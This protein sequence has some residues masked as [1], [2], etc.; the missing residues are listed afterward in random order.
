M[1]FGEVHTTVDINGLSETIMSEAKIE[2]LKFKYFPAYA[3]FLLDNNL[4]EFAA[5]MLQ[6]SREVNL[7]LLKLFK[8][9]PE[10][11]LIKLGIQNTRDSLT[12]C[13]ANKGKELI[14]HSIKMWLNNEIPMI[15]RDLIVADDI[16]LVSFVRRK[17]FRDFLFLYTN[18]FIAYRNIMEEIDQFTTELETI[19]LNVLLNR[20][21][22]LYKQAQALAHIGNWVWDL[23]KNEL[24]WSEELYNIYELE[25][26]TE[27]NR[28]IIGS[29]NHPDDYI[30][31]MQQMQL[32]AETHKP[33]DF[34]YR[35]I[36]KD[37][38][39]KIL[40]AKGQL[41]VDVNNKPLQFFGTLQ[42][43]TV[44]KRFEKELMEKQNFIQKITHVTPSL[45]VTYNIQTGKYIFVNNALKKLLGYEPQEA[46]DK[47]IGFFMP[48]IHPDDLQSVT[49]K[50]AKAIEHANQSNAD[51]ETI[52][53]FQYRL[54]HKNGEYRWFHT[55]GTIFGHDNHGK[56]EYVLNISVD[57]THQYLLNKRLEEEKIA[58]QKY[59]EEL[60]QS[61]DRYHRMTA[62][63]QDYA[64]LLLDK[65]GTIQNWNLGA[66]K[67]KG[68]KAEEII[69]KNFRVFYTDEDRQNHR[70]DKLLKQAIETGKANDE[71]WRVRKDGTLFWGS[72][73]ITALHDENYDV[74]GFS[75]VTRDLTQRKISEDTMQEYAEELAKKNEELRRS[76]ERY[77]RMIAEVQDYAILLLDKEGTI[78]NWNLGAEKIKG[79]KAEEI[80]GKNFRIFYTEEDRQN[81]RPDKLL[82]QAI[83]TG[84]ANDEGWRVRKDGTRFWGSIVITALH[85]ENNAVIGL[86]KVTRDL[87]ER[88]I[89]EEKLKKNAEELEY[90]NNELIKTNKELESFNYIASHDLQEPLHKIQIFSDAILSNDFENLSEKGKK[91]FNRMFNAANRMQQLIEDF[92][93]FSRATSSNAKFEYADLNVLLREVL[94]TIHFAIEDSKAVIKSGA[95]PSAYVIPFQF[96]QVL[97]NLISNS[98]KYR[99]QGSSPHITISA[100]KILTKNKS[101]N[102]K[103]NSEYLMLTITDEGIGFDQQ[104]A[105]KI[106]ELFQRLHTKEEYPGTGIGLA[107]V[108]KIIQNHHG[109]IRAKSSPGKG[110]TFQIY[111]PLIRQVT[112]RV[113]AAS[114]PG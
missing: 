4:E 79:Y 81:H 82:K 30:Y 91:Y 51:N 94:S 84:K 114:E 80:I 57:V 50:N 2:K 13:A 47:G 65:E 53:E 11:Q 10:E 1:T 102:L 35:I 24:I 31:V 32:L 26:G 18:D 7:P 8:S 64:I 46:M 83:E 39:E 14:E 67:I 101:R 15:S 100:K 76:E 61:E 70:P 45:I 72:I 63:V 110:A 66:E 93:A 78:Q 23:Q 105:K 90:K 73:V 56:V 98:I 60:R 97:Q 37:G 34:F 99:Q 95:L 54:L 103:P 43:V 106:F 109:V 113:T 33:H 6:L 42:D 25:P 29:Y 12:F 77:H 38:R 75:K 28:E 112:K 27:I 86:S 55:Y 107:I 48:L 92:L 16:T 44:Q 68:Y 108:K 89:A 87:T 96:R 41:L 58:A 49:E 21:Q 9:Y 22:G 71:G 3:Q 69:G 5:K 17:A 104:Y 88:K 62:E 52:V 74:I 111:I 85:G 36:L 20:Q 40:H 19:F 59:A